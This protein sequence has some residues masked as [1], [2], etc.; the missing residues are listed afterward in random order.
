MN[1]N[2]IIGT[3]AA[4][5]MTLS[6][7]AAAQESHS[8][9]ASLHLVLT[10]TDAQTV[11]FALAE[12]PKLTY[13][14]S[15]V[16][17]AIGQDAITYS[18]DGIREQHFETKTAT[19]VSDH[20]RQDSPKPS[21]SASGAEFA[22]LRPN[23]RIQ[24]LTANGQLVMTAVADGEGHATVRLDHLPTGVYILR[25]PTKSYKMVNK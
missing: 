12:S 17:I 21:F 7:P 19:N 20:L 11:S 2:F 1:K 13:A 3:V 24:V 4:A 9:T 25:T 5:A 22:G 8:E 6:L 18:L 23:D 14:G 16:T 10:Q 15:E